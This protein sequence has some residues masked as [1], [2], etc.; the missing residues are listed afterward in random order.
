MKVILFEDCKKQG[1]NSHQIKGFAVDRNFL[2]RKQ[3]IL[4]IE[5]LNI[6]APVSLEKDRL[7]INLFKK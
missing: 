4:G 7:N 1:L 5:E 2:F 3:P 6:D